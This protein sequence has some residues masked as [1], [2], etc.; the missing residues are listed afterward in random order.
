VKA[1]PAAFA[2]FFQIPGRPGRLLL[3]IQAALPP[4]LLTA[5]RSI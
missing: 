4:F 5:G 1:I 3:D 2:A